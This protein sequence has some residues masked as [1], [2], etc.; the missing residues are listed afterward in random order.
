MKLEKQ[1]EQILRSNLVHDRDLSQILKTKGLG[2]SRAVTAL[3]FVLLKYLLATETPS[4]S[5]CPAE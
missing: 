3:I 1:Q 2:L 4:G 5:I